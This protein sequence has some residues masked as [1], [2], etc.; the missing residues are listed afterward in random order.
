ML[1]N[2]AFAIQSTQDRT[3]PSTVSL[4]ADRPS[5]RHVGRISSWN[6]EKGYGFVMPHAGG[7]RTFLHIKSFQIGSRRP[8]DGDLISYAVTTDSRG[9][10]SAAEVRFAGH[11][12]EVAKARKPRKPIPR[13]AIGIAW[14]LV[15]V[16]G[17]ILGILPVVITIG[18]VFLSPLSYVMY[19]LDKDAAG[20]GR[21]RTPESTLH[22]MDLL[23]GWPGALIAQQQSRHKTG[24]LSFQAVFWTTVLLNIA[25]VVWLVRSGI[26][27]ALTALLLGGWQVGAANGSAV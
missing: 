9:R 20:K 2:L 19:A 14:L 1:N 16:V 25:A 4:P 27:G 24:K 26:A 18:Y 5:M 6:E 15:S 3:H 23:G 22:V 12:I 11:K 8:V 13:L 17:S 7:S 21:Q 10:T